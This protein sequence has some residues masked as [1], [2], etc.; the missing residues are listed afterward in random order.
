[1]AK[2]LA[3]RVAGLVEATGRDVHNPRTAFFAS[4]CFLCLL[5]VTV[6]HFGLWVSAVVVIPTLSSYLISKDS[7]LHTY[8]FIF[9]HPEVP[10]I[11]LINL[12]T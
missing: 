11:P 1:M 7:R 2:A 6:L 5:H 4:Q 12:D 3:E 8:L 9:L 10:S